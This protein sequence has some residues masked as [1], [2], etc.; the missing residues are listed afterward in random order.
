MMIGTLTYDDLSE[1]GHLQPDGWPDIVTDFKFY[2]ASAFCIPVKSTHGNR[3]V[4]T[5]AAIILGD[6]AWLAHII[7]DKEYR[8]R[9]IGYSIVGEL[10][11]RLK[12]FPL[13]SYLLIS[14]E[15][16]RPLYE[17]AG[18][19]AVT[20]YAFFRREEP[21]NGQ[22][23]PGTVRPYEEAFISDILDLDRKISGEDRGILFGGHLTSSKICVRNHSVVGAYIPDLGEGL[24]IADTESAGT[25]LMRLKYSVT[26][27]A[28]LPAE[29]VTGI[30]FLEHN[31][32][33]RT[34]VKGTR[35]VYGEDVK[36]KPDKIFSRIGGNLG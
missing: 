5:G 18:F 12:G 16:G 1:L 31:G 26:D 28:V 23:G 27:K 36:W 14:T 11:N 34:P 32:F 7:V 6:S 29:N 15:M 3:I 9:G 10:M 4:G 35:M 2:L 25:E 24:I 17:K 8:N 20:E 13:R 22:T 21:W 19:K 30:S 33:V